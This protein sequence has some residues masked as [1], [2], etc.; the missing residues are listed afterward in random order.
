MALPEAL[1]E[2][3]DVEAISLATPIQCKHLENWWPM[4][5]HSPL[6]GFLR[7]RKTAIS[8]CTSRLI[9]MA[10]AVPVPKQQ[11][12]VT[13]VHTADIVYMAKVLRF[14]MQFLVKVTVTCL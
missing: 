1:C 4:L 3:V 13:E 10:L 12:S 11:T 9:V 5:G 14:A 8:P 6:L 2:G 7:K